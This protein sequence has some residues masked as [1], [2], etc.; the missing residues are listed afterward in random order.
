MTATSVFLTVAICA[1]L[2]I[3][4]ASGNSHIQ[5]KLHFQRPGFADAKLLAG[6][7][8]TTAERK[9]RARKLL[10]NAMLQVSSG[11][12]QVQETHEVHVSDYGADPN[13]SRDS[14]VPLSNAIDAL[15]KLQVG[16]N[17]QGLTDLGGATLNLDG[18]AYLI[19]KSLLIPQG[20]ANFKVYGGSLIAAD[21]FTGLQGGYLLQIGDANP[22]NRTSGGKG[23]KDCISDI[24][25][26]ELTLDGRNVAYGGLMVE[27]AMDVNIGPAIFVI[28][29]EGVGISLRGSGAGYIH[30]AW[31]GQFEAGSPIPRI[32]ATAT[33]ILMDQGQ[34]DSD[35]FNVIVFSGLVGVNSTNGANRLQGVHTWNLAG[36]DGGIGIVLHSGAGR[37]EQCYL[38]YAPLV[39]RLGGSKY[40]QPSLGMI[41]GN[42]FLGSSTIVLQAATPE[43]VIRGLIITGNIFNTN[44]VPNKTFT[45]DE[46]QGKFVKLEDT[47]IENNE[48][49][50]DRAAGK[51]SSIATKTIEIDAGFTEG[52]I[53][54]NGSL[55]FGPS[56]GIDANSVQCFVHGL[57]ACGVSAVPAVS[58]PLALHVVL[59]V[60]LKNAV[61]VTCTVDQSTR[62]CPAH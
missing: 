61:N 60:G 50:L 25:V 53:N 36:S 48:V 12:L 16:T 45:L 38:D 55:V 29:Y 62:L 19:S 42:F 18:G 54:Y 1:C 37:V 7:G 20:Y 46:T 51:I 33:A 32:N 58:P 24:S 28:G 10:T 6:P 43:V 17:D 59:S 26:Q 8:D 22:C 34:H 57:E 11:L 2:C 41:E 35:V 40:W 14:T 52:F 3:H 44:N 39:L 56:I 31:L 23:N 13:A 21:N 15:L 49:D 27:N 47:V 4:S 5:G 30:E 9:R